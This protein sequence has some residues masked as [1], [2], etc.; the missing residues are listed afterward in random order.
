MLV[1]LALAMRYGWWGVVTDAS[2]PLIGCNKEAWLLWSGVGGFFACSF[3]RVYRYHNVLV[4]IDGFMSPVLLQLATLLLP[5]LVPPAYF[6]A[7]KGECTF[8][9]DTQ[10]CERHSDRPE[11]FAFG[12]MVVLVAA[13]LA[14]TC[15]LRGVKLQVPIPPFSMKIVLCI[16]APSRIPGRKKAI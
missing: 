9:Q 8:D 2:A 14:L 3:L 7:H 16:V 4:L 13:T 11:Q 5:F 6:V 12:V 15:S 10:E 1:N